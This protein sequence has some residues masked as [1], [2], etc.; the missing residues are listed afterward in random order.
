MIPWWVSGRVC[1]SGLHMGR[2]LNGTLDLWTLSSIM[3][4]LWLCTLSFADSPSDNRRRVRYNVA[5][6]PVTVPS[7]KPPPDK[8]NPK[9]GIG[10][11]NVLCTAQAT[12]WA[13]NHV[14]VWTAMFRHQTSSLHWPRNCHVTYLG[15]MQCRID[16]LVFSFQQVTS[17]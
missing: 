13:M 14:S 11:L 9:Q 3:D 7:Q 1:A 4:G 2:S 10:M 17:L 5:D 15:F 8:P 6:L 16:L 12:P